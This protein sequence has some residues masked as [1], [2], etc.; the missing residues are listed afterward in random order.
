MRLGAQASS[1][2]GRKRP[3][4][5]EA[6]RPTVSRS[7]GTDRVTT[8]AATGRDGE[9]PA[10]AAEADSPVEVLQAA[11]P[12]VKRPDAVPDVPGEQGGGAGKYQHP[13]PAFRRR[14]RRA[15]IASRAAFPGDHRQTPAAQSVG[16][17]PVC[18]CLD[19][20]RRAASVWGRKKSSESKRRRA[21][22]CCLDARV[23][24][25]AGPWFRGAGSREGDPSPEIG[26]ESE[27]SRRAVV[28]TITSSSTPAWPAPTGQ[29]ARS[30]AVGHSSG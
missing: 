22:P 16:R 25:A 4:S 1:P 9:R 26:R 18:R 28:D 14:T 15:G 23:A 10:G 24:A 3:S 5:R 21:V 12:A 6:D 2:P 7:G 13:P 17:E 30:R 20:A 11:Q 19:H 8:A 27:R 29:R